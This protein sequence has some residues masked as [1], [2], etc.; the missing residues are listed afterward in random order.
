MVARTVF[1]FRVDGRLPEHGADALAGMDI[2]EVPP[3]L[4]MRGAVVDEAHLHGI[5]AQLRM[6]GL[7]VVSVHPLSR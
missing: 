5:I 1:Q 2:E 6:L 7:T 3:G 4:L